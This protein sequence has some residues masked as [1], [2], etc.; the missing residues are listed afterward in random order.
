LQCN[1]EGQ[2]GWKQKVIAFRKSD[3]LRQ[4]AWAM[5]Q[6]TITITS[7]SCPRSA[8]G[9][10]DFY[11]E[12]VYWWPDPK[13]PDGPYIQRDGETNPENFVADRHAMIRFS[14]IVGDL[15]AAYVVTRNPKYAKAAL[16][17]IEGWFVDTA[18]RMNP[19]L[20]YA[21]AIHGRTKGRGIG[22]IDTIHLMEVAQ[23]IHLFEE[24]GLIPPAQLAAIKSWFADYVHWLM[25]SKNGQDEMHAKNTHGTC[26]AMQ[27][28]SFAKVNN[29]TVVL[30]FCRQRYKQVLLPHQMAPN[31][32]FPL[33][34][35]RTKPYG[36]SLF[37]LDAMST[38][39]QIL[40][41][42]TH[43]LWTYKTPDGRS[44]EKGIA[45]MFPY[46]KHKDTW[47]EKPDVMYWK[48]W[49]VAQPFLIF[50]AVAYDKP[51]WFDLWK[52]LKHDLK[53]DEIIRNVPI[54]HPLIWLQ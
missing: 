25:N 38:L 42:S 33:E 7:F 26:W 5:H 23:A 54:R 47:P 27:V 13:N 35:R 6:K 53:V 12:G 21:Q 40:S 30:N 34:L 32:S 22:I 9:R 49:P 44:I 16:N 3:I 36:Y 19:N 28:A 37:N 4:A 15:A 1:S 45:F 50:G 20:Q 31:G 43:D 29:D 24:A 39:C 17:H 18:T 41:D 10:H 52:G 46:V 11:S 48:Y 2:P 8:G 51:A 14:T